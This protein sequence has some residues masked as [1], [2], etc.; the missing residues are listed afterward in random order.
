M[1]HILSHD[2]CNDGVVILVFRLLEGRC[3]FEEVLGFK[4]TMI[5]ENNV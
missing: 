2:A 1:S 5:C 4:V 3:E